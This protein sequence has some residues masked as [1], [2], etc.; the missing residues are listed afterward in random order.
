MNSKSEGDEFAPIMSR[1][2]SGSGQKRVGSFYLD[3]YRECFEFYGCYYH[4]CHV[5]FPDR[6]KV[7][8][9]KYRE[10]GY[11]TVEKAYVDTMD[12]E[13]M[14]K[15]SLNFE[16]EKDK[17]IVLWEHE[18]N[19]M[20][21]EMKKELGERFV[22]NVV[23]KLNPRDAVKGGRTETFRMHVSVRV[24]DRQSISYLDVNSLY[25]YVM[26]VTE[27]P[28]GHP[29]IR[30]GDNSCRLLIN[31]LRKC[32]VPFLGVCLVRVL[33]P[34]DLML[35][36]LPHKTDGKL[37]FFLCRECSLNGV[38][39]RRGCTHDEMER[40]WIDTYTSIDIDGALKVGY[41]ILEYY[42]VWHYPSGGSAFFKDFILNIIRRK[43]ECSGFPLNCTTELEK[44]KYV[45]DLM[46]KSMI[47]TS[48]ENIKND[49]AGR[50]LNKIMANSVWGKWTQNPSGQ[51]EVKTCST[52]REYHKCLHTGRVKRV[53]LI[54]DRLLQVEMKQDRDIDGENREKE[55][56]RVGLGGKN[57]II[58]AFVTAASRDLMY[59]R[60]L[61]KLNFD[62]L[63]YTDT[64]SV[65][66]YLDKDNVDHVSLPTSDLLGDL[67]D[68]YGDLF[69]D[70]PTWYISE[71]MAFGPK[72]C[73]IIVKDK[74]TGKVV[75]WVKTMKGISLK[76]NVTMFTNDKI[77]LYRNPVLDFCCVLQYGSKFHYTSM[78]EIWRAMQRL[79]NNRK[80][81]NSLSSL[82]YVITLD[83]I[84][85][86]RE[87]MNVFTDRFVTGQPMKKKVRVTQCKRFPKPDK[88]ISFG[89]TFPIG[90]S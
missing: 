75:K 40:S 90:W 11:L 5:C 78:Q 19:D 57:P 32:G 87:L 36:Y 73:Q 84:V 85:F 26:S 76:G 7:V 23:G 47:T 3:G 43:I 68:E 9:S 66:I 17:W 50:Y 83:Q 86:K 58:G 25:P 56:N 64:D 80:R 51:Q 20:E 48:I 22:S 52:I 13:C 18:Y 59:F 24:P 49:P 71:L 39:Q 69:C 67:K 63:L 45:D 38:V 65:I 29:E 41:Q 61:S 12:R 15:H 72:M 30:R 42:E 55:N 35:S 54:S 81:D 27:F 79:K 53:T 2:C 62:Q 46:E 60:Y 4:G 8:R 21:D 33:A 28:V 14:I 74:C 34:K 44:K 31:N 10:N 6:S 37:M 77:P 88:A 89:V 16:D 70:N 82:S 1:Y